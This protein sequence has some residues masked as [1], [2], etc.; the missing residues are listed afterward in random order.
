MPM[1]LDESIAIA[2]LCQAIIA[3]LY[4]LHEQNLTLAPL[5]PLAHYGE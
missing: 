5:Q 2:A 4:K 1:R 3:K